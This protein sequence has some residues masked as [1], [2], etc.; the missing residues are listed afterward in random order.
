[1]ASSLEAVLG[2]EPFTVIASAALLANAVGGSAIVMVALLRLPAR[3]LLGPGAA[4]NLWL[5]PP[6]AA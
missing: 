4:Y 6:L 5:L 1:M 2:P 3:R